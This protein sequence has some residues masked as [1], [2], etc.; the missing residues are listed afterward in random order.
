MAESAS[1]G[2]GPVG[3]G[4]IR[5]DSLPRLTQTKDRLRVSTTNPAAVKN[6]NQNDNSRSAFGIDS[7]QAGGAERRDGFRQLLFRRRGVRFVASRHHRA[8]VRRLDGGGRA[9]QRFAQLPGPETTPPRSPS[10]RGKAPDGLTT[11]VFQQ[12]LVGTVG[13]G[14]TRLRRTRTGDSNSPLR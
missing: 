14:R 6:P 2:S 10:T 13:P 11:D 12:G 1:R 8:L 5:G 4:Q 9:V 3:I 7:M